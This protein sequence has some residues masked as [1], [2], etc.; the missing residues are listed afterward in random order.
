MTLDRKSLALPLKTRLI[1]DGEEGAASDGRTFERENP[2]NAS[3]TVT[4]SV[5]ATVDDLSLIHI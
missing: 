1:I 3:E 4:V 2:A 5:R